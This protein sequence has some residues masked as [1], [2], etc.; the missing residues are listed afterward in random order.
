MEPESSLSCSQEPPTS[1]YPKPDESSP[2]PASQSLF[3]KIHFNII[4]PYLFRSFKWF[5]QVFIQKPSK[6]TSVLHAT[7]PTHLNFLHLIILI[8]NKFGGEY[9]FLIM[10]FSAVS[11]YFF[12]LGS[13]YSQH[14]VVIYLSLCCSLHV[15]DQ[16]WHQF[17]TAGKIIVLYILIIVFLD[18]M[19]EDN[20]FWVSG[21]TCVSSRGL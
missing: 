4:L 17:K 16:V 20:R 9:K 3:Y 15:R 18:S 8:T 7:R 10:R 5:L 1:P 2:Y 11:Y 6:H 12:L 13:K 21:V 19:Q 14:P